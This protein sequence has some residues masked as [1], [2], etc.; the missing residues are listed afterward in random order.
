MCENV[1]MMY[2]FLLRKMTRGNGGLHVPYVVLLQCIMTIV[3][4]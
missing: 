2:L 3:S 1:A 4:Q